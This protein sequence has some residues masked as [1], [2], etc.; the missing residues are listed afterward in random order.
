MNHKATAT[1]TFDGKDELIE[2]Y[3]TIGKG[4]PMAI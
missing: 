4:G 1:G 3:N 2:M